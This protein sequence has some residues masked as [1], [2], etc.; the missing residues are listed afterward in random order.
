[1][2]D[3]DNLKKELADIASKHDNLDVQ[4]A[5]YDEHTGQLEMR[6]AVKGGPTSPSLPPNVEIIGKESAADLIGDNPVMPIHKAAGNR[7]L[8]ELDPLSRGDLDL[9]RT[10]VLSDDPSALIQRS[11]DYYRTKDVYGTAINVLTNF[12]SKGFEN[13]IDDP[14]IKAVFD[15]WVLDTGFD[16]TVEDIFFDFFRAG[17]VRTYKIMGKY[18]PDINFLSSHPKI[19]EAAKL[20]T[21]K[22]TALHKN[23]YSKTHVPIRYTILNPTM[24]TIKGSL[25]FGQTATF[26]KKEAGQEIKVLLEMDKADLSEFQKKVIKNLPAVFK[27]A[28]LDGKDIPLDPDLIGEVDYRRMPYE[29]YPIPRGARAFEAVEFKDELRKADYST[30]DGITNYILL[31]KVGN[32]QYPIQKQETLERAAE[33]FDTVSKSYKVV[34]NHTLNVEKITSPEIGQVLGQDK[35]KQVNDDITG[36]VGIVRA[37]IDGLGGANQKATELATKSVI[38]EINYAR[39]Q[40]ARWIYKE[41]RQVAKA[42]GFDR[43]PK[44]RFDDMALRDEVQMMSLIQGMI[45]RRI[46]SYRT[47]QTALG[48]DPETELAQMQEE[49]KLIQD[50]VLGLVGSPFQQ[51]G[52]GTQPTQ[53]TP[54]GTP[55]EGRPKAQPAPKKPADKDAPR[56][57]GAAPKGKAAA[58]AELPYVLVDT[59]ENILQ[60]M[61]IEELEQA[62]AAKKAVEGESIKPKKKPTRRKKKSPPKK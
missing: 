1:M 15:N 27:K 26:L 61:T 20:V 30:L 21:G 42:M 23:R 7:R 29:R 47:G 3:K 25:M 52:G 55:S 12:A 6:L 2:A 41:Y 45:D 43:I 24:V 35:Y 34:W 56:P 22:E 33:L 39:R 11:I 62:L 48:F 17:L 32:D 44:V 14:E 50:G 4:S 38:E 36:A 51:S 13:D 59:S 54:K 5:D 9:A 31:I 46:I 60:N 10:S 58:A 57:S 28:I 37:L 16:K 53:N 49:K 8:I 19:P 40:V 18:E